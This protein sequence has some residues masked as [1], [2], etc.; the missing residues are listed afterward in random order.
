MINAIWFYLT[1]TQFSKEII[2][3]T[4][5]LWYTTLVFCSDFGTHLSYKSAMFL[6]ISPNNKPT[7]YTKF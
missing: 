3:K 7:P 4:G 1:E 5:I 2:I 6:H